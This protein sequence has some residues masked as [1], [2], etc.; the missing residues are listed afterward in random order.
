MSSRNNRLEVVAVDD[1]AARPALG[2]GMVGYGFMGAAHSQAWRTAAHVL[3]LPL[4]P[5]MVALCGRDGA[6]AGAAA[7]R[8]GW[9]AAESDWRALIGR[10]DVQLIDIC[11]PGDAHA[12]IAI[13]A[14]DA[15]Q[16]VL[17]E[18]PLAT[19]MPEAQAMAAA[20]ARASARGVRSMIGFNYRRVPAVALARELVRAGRIGEIRHVRASYLQ[21]WLAD[22]SFPLTWR[23][24]REH[25]GSGALGD[26]GSHI[27]DLAQYLSGGLITGV[28]GISATFV[29]ERPIAGAAGAAPEAGAVTVDDA[30][31]FTARLGPALGSFEATRFASGRKNEL[32]IE[33][34]GER[35]SLAFNLEQLNEL[36]FYDHAQD[37]ET[38]GFRRILVTE[39][40]HPY[41]SAWWPPGHVLGWDVT[42]THEIADLVTAIAAGTDPAP[43]FAD[44][45]QVQRVLAAVEDSAA[46]QSRWTPV[47][48]PGG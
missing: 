36:Q 45:L 10:P 18:K 39:P 5:R 12:E 9:A 29:G 30:A 11:A 37:A 34:N 48:P 16:H 41:L 21:D 25:A 38:A 31:L 42:F 26:L 19:T 1:V 20:A 46:R 14:L 15:G 17:C 28:S 27:V 6:A 43:S 4:T 24:Q 35:G 2:V 33:L 3:D 23:L 47:P 13:A 7:R 32:R 40:G 22:P 44:G 8:Y